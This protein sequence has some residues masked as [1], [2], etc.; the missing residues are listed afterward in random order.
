MPT[1]IINLVSQL[2]GRQ[3]VGRQAEG[4]AGE[5]GRADSIV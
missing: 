1:K 4:M 5:P 3:A 2:A